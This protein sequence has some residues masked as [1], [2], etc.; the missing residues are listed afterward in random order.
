[1]VIILSLIGAAKTQR[2]DERRNDGS[3]GAGRAAF[4]I[5]L[6]IC[7]IDQPRGGRSGQKWRITAR[8]ASPHASSFLAPTPGIVPI[9]SSVAGFSV[10]I[11]RNTAS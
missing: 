3:G 4:R 2:P 7:E 5:R 1:M 11:A 8:N 9:A 6:A 10:A